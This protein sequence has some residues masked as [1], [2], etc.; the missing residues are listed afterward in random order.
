MPVTDSA[1]TLGEHGPFADRIEGFQAR[2]Q[3]LAM[4]DAVDAAIS[5]RRSLVIEAGTGTGKTF[6][7]LVPA[8]L[9]GER[10]IVSTGTKNL[11]DQLFHRD[12]PGVCS[13]LNI[14]PRL[15][16]LKGRSNYLC[17]HRLDE[18]MHSGR[19]PTRE[20]ASRLRGVASWATST[21]S[22]DLSE[23]GAMLDGD[24]LTPLVTS[25]SENCL[26]ADCSRYQECFV[27]LARR[28]AMEAEIV[29]VNHHLLLADLALK[30]EGF[31]ELLPGAAAIIVDEAH[32]LAETASNFFG[33][34]LS[35]RQILE[36]A[37]DMEVAA[38]THAREQQDLIDSLVSLKKPVQD[39][40]LALGQ[41]KQRAALH[42]VLHKPDLRDAL[43]ELR[44]LLECVRAELVIAADRSEDLEHGLA[45][46]EVLLHRLSLITSENDQSQIRWFETYGQGFMFNATP[47]SIADAFQRQIQR[48][49]N[50]AWIFTSAT[51]S[52]NSEFRHFT[53]QLG[54]NDAQCVQLDSPFNY[55]EQSLLYVPSLP[56]PDAPHY[57]DA[58]L[59]AIV[60]VLKASRG[61]AFLLFT[62]YR[63]LNLMA[64]KLSERVSYPLLVHGEGQ[65][66]TRMLEEFRRL[67]N[68]VLLGTSSFWEGVDVRGEALSLVVIDRLPFAAPDDPVLK[69]RIDAHRRKG[70]N[71]FNDLQLP[72]AVI[73][74]KQGAGRLIR[75]VADSGV[76][77]IADPRLMSASYGAIFRKS[78][79][80]MPLTRE[81]KDVQA[82][83]K[84]H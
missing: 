20:A 65:S 1:F 40:R 3:Q 57:L 32:Q 22:G 43:D 50:S 16:L 2:P 59:D 39:I 75:D 69:A 70:G 18:A 6:A 9:S 23:H 77:M 49:K 66:R 52:V 21:K 26:G 68:A 54:L 30:E 61:R 38:R 48:Y 4:A 14:K 37:R 8:L 78:L 27:V 45:R 35:S 67:G 33:E 51:L 41:D 7:Y 10:V 24:P 73:T 81:L 60:P 25:N 28:A 15:A 64:R 55:A 82:F 72:R 11:Q 83:F 79:P 17:L 47:L 46:S 71:P 63:A 13:A 80:A 5:E 34:S 29:V 56:E 36:L 12:L 74:L 84:S 19:L 76:L 42:S 58:M 31:G 44:R 53:D 62:S